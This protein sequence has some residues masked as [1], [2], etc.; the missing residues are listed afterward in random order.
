MTPH[1][2]P[3]Q[4]SDAEELVALRIAAMRPSLEQLGRFDALRARTRF[5]EH[6]TP[7][8]TRH[9]LVA[10]QR[11]GV[12]V[13]RHEAEHLLLDH[14]YVH[15]DHQGQGIGAAVLAGVFRQA[16]AQGLPVKVTALRG[17]RSND[18]YQHHGFELVSE[19]EWDLVY[20]RRTGIAPPSDGS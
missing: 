4:F 12:V 1:Y 8:C 7:D 16:E 15:P 13:L 3:A 11:V 18:F 14:L 2:E 9:L 17:S 20:V 6:F 19:S 10:G 5:L